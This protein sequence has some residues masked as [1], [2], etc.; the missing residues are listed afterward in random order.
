MTKLGNSASELDKDGLTI[1]SDEETKK[2]LT[3]FA[4]KIDKSLFGVALSVPWKRG[5][6]LLVDSL[7]D[8]HVSE[9]I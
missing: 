7:F 5:C 8:C 1:L 3:P 2:I 9:K 4:F 6:A